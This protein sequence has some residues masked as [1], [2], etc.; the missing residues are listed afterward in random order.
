M[1]SGD[2]GAARA[3]AVFGDHDGDGDGDADGAFCSAVLTSGLAVAAGAVCT[4]FWGDTTPAPAVLWAAAGEPEPDPTPTADATDRA[5]DNRLL[6]PGH[7]PDAVGLVDAPIHLPCSQWPIPLPPPSTLIV[8]LLPRVQPR[9]HRGSTTDAS[10]LYAP[11]PG[12]V[13]T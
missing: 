2:L 13:I 5:G 12:V 7:E 10:V 6:P 3:C 9:R 1:R 4:L 11:G 8:R